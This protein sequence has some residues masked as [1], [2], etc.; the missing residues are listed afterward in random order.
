M[1]HTSSLGELEAQVNCPY[2][3]DIGQGATIHVEQVKDPMTK[4]YDSLPQNYICFPQTYDDKTCLEGQNTVYF[5]HKNG[6]NERV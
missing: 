4:Q 3:H 5:T 2:L 1:L 6:Q